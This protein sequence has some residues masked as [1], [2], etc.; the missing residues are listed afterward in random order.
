MDSRPARL[1]CPWDFPGKNTRVGCIS[2]QAS[3]SRDWTQVSCIVGR[4]ST[5]W[6]TRKPKNTGIGS[7]SLLQGIF[8][9]R[10][11]NQGLLHCRQILYQLSNEVGAKKIGYLTILQL[12][13]YA[14]QEH[15]CTTNNIWLWLREEAQSYLGYLVSTSQCRQWPE[16]DLP[17]R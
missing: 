12:L 6:A 13:V 10:K 11:S 2:H 15:A 1:P 9:T 14:C 8:P 4:F 3:L 16:R 5:S 17:V 7:L